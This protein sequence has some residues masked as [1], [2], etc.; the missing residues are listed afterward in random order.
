MPLSYHPRIGEVLLCNYDTGFIVPEMVKLRPVIVV[1][2]R[3]RRREGLVAVVPLST[4]EPD[5]MM[6]Y[7][8]ELT[9]ARP[10]PMPF[11]SPTMWA[12]CDM[13][14]TLALSRLDRFKEARRDGRPRQYRTGLL[15]DDQIVRV[16]KG[17]L[18]GL[19][20]GS[21]TIHI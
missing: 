18:H 7:Q 13:V 14:T 9:L 21:L 12:K 10:L 16:K 8:I 3:L 4:S 2:P 17:I 11:N 20:L 1:S 5:V 19:G 6:D 15:S